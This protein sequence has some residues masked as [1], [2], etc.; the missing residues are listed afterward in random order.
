MVALIYRI[1]KWIGVGIGVVLVMWVMTGILIPGDE[2][3]TRRH[4]LAGLARAMVPPAV[5]IRVAQ[6]SQP[7]PGAIT[8]VTL[9]ALGDRPVYE[10]RWEEDGR[11]VDAVSGGMLDI[12]EAR[13][14]ALA[15]AEYPGGRIRS[16]E[17]IHRRD[18]GYQ[19][20]LFPVWRIRFDDQAGTWV[21]V[22][23]REARV[24]LNT[25]W[26]R[27]KTTMRGLHTFATL[28]ILRIPGDGIYPL[29]LTASLIAL[30]GIFTGYYL[31]LPKSCR[32]GG[33]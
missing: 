13:A 33:R 4:D 9:G 17:Q 11:I 19:F 14:R 22:A 16:V 20:G 10:V 27:A 23:T 28:R 1:H 32:P 24:V 21:H 8:S 6:A 29:L 25:R 30:A 3:P 12:D 26:D 2:R 7:S 15:E 5:A 31:S 18:R